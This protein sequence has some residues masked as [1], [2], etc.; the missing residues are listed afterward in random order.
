LFIKNFDKRTVELRQERQYGRIRQERQ[1][2]RS[3]NSWGF[4]IQL[5]HEIIVIIINQSQNENT[6][7]HIIG[8]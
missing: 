3:Q 2:G 1:Y 5:F 6:D 7:S 8:F 4:R